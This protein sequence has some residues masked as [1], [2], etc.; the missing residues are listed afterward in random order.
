M[1]TPIKYVKNNSPRLHQFGLRSKGPDGK[2][3]PEIDT[4]IN[5][6]PGVNEIDAALWE[7][8]MDQHN[9]L[10]QHLLPTKE[11]E[12]IES[13]KDVDFAAMQPKLALRLVEETYD[14][15]LLNRWLNDEVRPAVAQKIRDQLKTLDSQ[16]TPAR[17]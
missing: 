6:T 13:K 4:F 14:P 5:L 7:R 3:R 15:R 9:L 17:Q 2:L 10:N 11:I 16:T 12:V 8:A 1:P